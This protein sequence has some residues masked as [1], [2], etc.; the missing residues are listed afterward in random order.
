MIRQEKTQKEVALDSQKLA[1]LNVMAEKEGRKLKKN[2]I[3]SPCIL[4][5]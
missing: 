3:I 4:L 2:C 5:K 1:L